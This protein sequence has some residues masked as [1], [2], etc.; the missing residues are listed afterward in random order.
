MPH[1]IDQKINALLEQETSLRQWLE[2]I[3]ALTKDARGATVIAGLTQKETEEFLLL[4]P[5]VRAFDSGMTADHAAAARARHAE[6]KA[7]LE[8]ALQDN[9]IESLSGWGE[10]AA[11]AR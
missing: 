7:K 1:T 8:G 9:A 2:Q 4:S 10:A 6:L 5:L 3:R 11:A